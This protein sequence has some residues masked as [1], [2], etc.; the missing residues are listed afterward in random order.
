MKKSSLFTVLIMVV[1][2]G[3]NPVKAQAGAQLSVV[4]AASLGLVDTSIDVGFGPTGVKGGLGFGGG[5]IAGFGAMGSGL[6][7]GGLYLSRKTTTTLL[8]VETSTSTAFLH[9]PVMYRMGSNFSFGLGG[10]YDIG[11]SSGSG[12]AYGLTAGPR[13]KFSKLF[14]DARFNLDLKNTTANNELLFMLGYMC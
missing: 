12:S 2:F 10:F 8:G 5:L 7:I 4:G 3:M 1:L 14:V 11:L 9:I 6:E 13:I